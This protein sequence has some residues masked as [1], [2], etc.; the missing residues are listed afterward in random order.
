MIEWSH[1]V[2]ELM[3][4]ALTRFTDLTESE[5]KVL[6]AVTMG[7]FAYCGPS[8]D[9]DD[10]ANN[11]EHSDTW[12]GE[13]AARAALIRWLC[14]DREAS[15]LIDAR[16]IRI[17]GAR[18]IGEL[19]LSFTS[20]QFPLLFQ[21]VRF[22]ETTTLEYAKIEFLD[23]SRS[24]TG[25][26]KGNGLV[27]RTELALSEGFHS[28]GK[29]SLLGA[30]IGQDLTC[31]GGSFRNP[32][33]ESLNIEGAKV[34]GDLALDGGFSG[35]G[36]V[37]LSSIEI[38]GDLSCRGGTFRST[39]GTSLTVDNAKV[40]GSV[41]LSDGFRAYGEVSVMGA[42]IGGSLDASAGS[43]QNPGAGALSADGLQVVSD[44]LFSDG[45][46]AD[47]EVRLIGAKI[48]G[49]LN[50]DGAVFVGRSMLDAQQTTVGGAVF[51]TN[52]SNP[53][54]IDGKH[55]SLNL[56][57]TSA[58]PFDDDEGSWPAS[59]RL[60]LDG[61]EYARMIEST[62]DAKKRLEWLARQRSDRFC[63]Q[64]YR[65]L[66]RVLGATG[67]EAGARMVLIRLEDA[68][69]R[70]Q[71]VSY[72][73]L[74]KI[75]RARSGHPDAIPVRRKAKGLG[76]SAA[77][78][79]AYLQNLLLWLWQGVLKYTIAYGYRPH[80]ALGWAM[81][82]VVLGAF[83]FD[84]GYVGQLIV[85]TDKDASTSSINAKSAHSTDNKGGQASATS[86]LRFSAPVYSLD[87][88]LP[89]INL[90][91]KDH[92]AP[93]ANSADGWWL[94]SYLW[95]HIILGWVLSTFFVAGITG[96]VSRRL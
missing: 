81:L 86:Y 21:N 80:Y 87:T 67:D 58:G 84:R 74:A 68:R 26:I 36:A 17:Q 50:C 85:V 25:R 24:F 70:H 41:F 39:G 34:R 5:L 96:I 35:E 15:P 60:V 43:F 92:W 53:G 78:V 33:G 31:A 49:Q 48:A 79:V 75:R 11:P 9:G 37:L 27:I 94:R 2:I 71:R 76:G 46:C 72:R 47:G 57:L 19:D 51:W 63:P 3:Q 23:L 52:V 10:P 7:E 12:G 20:I 18:V 55:L 42:A 22:E 30:E 45:F 28:E 56:G 40:N 61:F 83:L 62:P 64:P 59:G 90:G 16:G 69:R 91:Q 32:V 73:R 29:V 89:I 65:Q 38:G 54:A 6:C 44:V 88:F 13:R 93:N 77:L 14:I 95:V 82:V 8:D 1:E 66:A 4:L